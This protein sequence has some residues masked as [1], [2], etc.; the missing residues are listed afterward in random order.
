MMKIDIKSY[1]PSS[2]SKRVYYYFHTIL[3]CSPDVSG[4]LTKLTTYNEYLPTGSPSSPR[5]AYYAYG[6]MW[7]RIYHLARKSNY[8]MTVYI[9]DLCI[10]GETIS[11][12]LFWEIKEIIHS[13]ELRYHKE[14]VYYAQPFKVTGVII[15]RNQ[16]DVPNKHLQ[17]IKHLKFTMSNESEGRDRKKIY[18]RLQGC[19]AYTSFVRLMQEKT[20]ESTRLG[21]RRSKPPSNPT[22]PVS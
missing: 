6:E 22:K 21:P 19:I 5:L 4:I 13:F 2:T 20:V 8:L 3:K 9:D 12:K 18:S 14:K 11:R 16:L 1:F 17:K 10:S 7:D 15:Y